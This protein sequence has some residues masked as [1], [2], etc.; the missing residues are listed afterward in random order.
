M[1]FSTTYNGLVSSIPL[2]T[3]DGSDDLAANINTI[4][5][6]AETQLL[7]DLDL[8]MFQVRDTPG[9]L[10]I[11][12]SAWARPSGFVK[13]NGLW[14]TK[15]SGALKAIKKR[16]LSY[17]LANFPDP[18]VVGEPTYYADESEA[19]LTFFS[20]PDAAYLVTVYGI[21][22]PL[23]LGPMNQT[24]WLSNYAADL[25]LLAC[26]IWSEQYLTNPAMVQN[27]KGEYANDRLPKAKMELR[28]LSRATYE[29]YRPTAQPGP[30]L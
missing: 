3:E 27:W 1:S 13:I 9:M 24:T 12:T 20:A 21:Q 30:P 7:R 11:N 6:N 28:G 23:G 18:T 17:C 10:T 5:A 4:I 2:L 22:R 14:I 16:T 15:A 8:E 29:Y 19:D 26:L 25:L